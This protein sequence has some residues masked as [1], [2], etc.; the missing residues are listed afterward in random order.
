MKYTLIFMWILSPETYNIDIN[1]YTT[2]TFGYYDT[3]QSCENAAE[4][5][6]QI[7]LVANNVDVS[8]QWERAKFKSAFICAAVPE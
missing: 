2:E 7:E 6:L 5:R 1:D 8:K 4:L 3:L